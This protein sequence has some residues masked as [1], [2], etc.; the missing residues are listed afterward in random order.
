MCGF[1]LE[2]ALKHPRFLGHEL[3]IL[4]GNWC[5]YQ[6]IVAVS[7]NEHW[8]ALFQQR[9]AEFA[10][11]T[12]SHGDDTVFEHPVIESVPSEELILLEA[13]IYPGFFGQNILAFVWGRRLSSL[14]S[15]S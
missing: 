6:Q 15:S 14:M 5:F 4:A 12:F 10:T 11:A 2:K 13:L 9:F 3:S 7:N 8:D 1:Y